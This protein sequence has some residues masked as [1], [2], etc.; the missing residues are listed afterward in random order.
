MCHHNTFLI[1][2]SIEEADRNRWDTV[3]HA[4]LITSLLVS[5]LFGIA[6]YATFTSYSQGDLLENYC[7]DDDLINLSRILFSVTILLTYPIECFVAREVVE[8]SLF[9]QDPN[10]PLPEKTH[11]V[12]TL[13][14]VSIT[15]FISMA[16]DCLGVVLELNVSLARLPTPN[17]V[18]PLPTGF[19]SQGVLAAV[20]LAYVLPA[21][22]YLKLEEGNVFSKRKLPALGLFLFGSLVA[23][24][25]LLLLIMDFDQVDTCSH[26]RV[27]PYCEKPPELNVHVN[28]STSVAA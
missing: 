11:Y 6:G 16:T 17:S 20:P 21:L 23:L 22:S 8:H 10:V 4:S 2:S 12:I 25:G 14:I 5:T 19:C 7:W 27:M 15:Y 26:G 24:L 3:T 28:I 18:P 9:V 1:Y 13:V